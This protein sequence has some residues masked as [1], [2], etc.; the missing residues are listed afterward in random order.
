MQLP[1]LLIEY[2]INGATSLIWLIPLLALFSTEIDKFEL[3]DGV[4]LLP[5]CYLLGMVIDFL[6]SRLLRRYKQKIKQDIRE[7]IRQIT[8]ND[9]ES[10]ELYA[11]AKLKLYSPELAQSLE[12][13]SSRD[14]I[15]RGSVINFSLATMVLT[16]HFARLNEPI[17]A[18]I[19]SLIGIV[20]VPTSVNMWTK[21][22]ASSYAFATASLI[23]LEE[24]LK[25]EEAKKNQREKKERT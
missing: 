1:G 13:R 16:I 20:L 9:Y 3:A 15:A 14:R 6:G 24:K 12:M 5:S 17:N 7:R 10:N 22:Q 18:V 21:F 2:L 8:G 23:T 19:C 4:I 25:R 11:E